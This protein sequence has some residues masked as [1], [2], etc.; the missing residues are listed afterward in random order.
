M[1]LNP[2]A[3]SPNSSARDAGRRRVKSPRRTRSIASVRARRGAWTAFARKYPLT[4]TMSTL[5]QIPATIVRKVAE[6]SPHIVDAV[7][8]GEVA[9]VI[10]TTVG[11][12]AIRDSYSIRR[13]ALLANIPYFTTM[14][15]ALAA[16]EALDFERAVHSGDFQGCP[17]MNYC[18]ADVP[19]TRITEHKHFAPW[20][21]HVVPC[22]RPTSWSTPRAS[23]P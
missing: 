4:S 23:S 12:K 1:W 17:V 10:N 16:A 19:Y 14:A 11:A 18:D 9:M 13:H 3:R 20:E 22:A 5:A 6:G 21:T 15:A 7:K 8:R 2:L